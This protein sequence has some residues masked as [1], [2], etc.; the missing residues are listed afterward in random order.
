[1]GVKNY[2]LINKSISLGLELLKKEKATIIEFK[3]K[4]LFLSMIILKVELI[5]YMQF[6]V[7][8]MVTL[9]EI[10]SRS[11]TIRA[12]KS[13]SKKMELFLLKFQEA[14]IFSR[15]KYNHI[16]QL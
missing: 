13:E 5:M 6:G 15:Q 14:L 10:Y 4:T 3:V 8:L 9:A 2:L 16:P 1:M 12:T 11:T 7:I